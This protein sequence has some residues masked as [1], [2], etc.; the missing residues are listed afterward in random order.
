MSA[1]AWLGATVV[2]L[3]WG[4]REA[5]H[6]EP[7][8]T[9]SRAPAPIVPVAIDETRDARATEPESSASRPCAYPPV[10]EGAARARRAIAVY[11][12]PSFYP[13]NATAK[14]REQLFAD[15]SAKI[16][17]LEHARL[18]PPHEID[19]ARAKV[20]DASDPCRGTPAWD[21]ALLDRYPNLVTVRLETVCRDDSVC[22]LTA[23]LEDE[24]RTG[25]ARWRGYTQSYERDRG[26][27][28]LAMTAAAEH[29]VP[30]GVEPPVLLP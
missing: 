14:R 19:V 18:I 24:A 30:M 26:D 1:R 3:A 12:M 28:A 4:C 17:A 20:G 10:A 13:E 25:N 7:H 6:E 2:A 16:A 27:E 22:A 15:V 8:A 23:T 9:Q 5:G 29:L 11:A 21:R